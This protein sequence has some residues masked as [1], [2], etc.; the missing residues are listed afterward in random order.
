M[1]YHVTSAVGP[2]MQENARNAVRATIDRLE[3]QRGLTRSEAY[4]L[5]S[6]AGGLKIAVTVLGDG[7]VANV[8]FH[9][10]H[11]IFAG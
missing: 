3:A 9:L 5:C 2:D 11:S 10:P 8:T 4:M 6:A 1:G 7:H